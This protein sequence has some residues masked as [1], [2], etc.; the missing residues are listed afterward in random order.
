MEQRKLMLYNPMRLALFLLVC[1]LSLLG[2]HCNLFAG[3]EELASAH[4][5]QACGPTDGPS[6]R[7]LLTEEEIGCDGVDRV[8][9]WVPGSPA[10]VLIWSFEGFAP[11][12]PSTLVIDPEVHEEGTAFEGGWAQ[13]CD[14]S[15]TCVDVERGTVAFSA[16]PKGAPAGS[17]TASVE[18]AFEDGSTISERYLVHRCKPEEPVLCG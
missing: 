15:G 12:V 14:A 7:I 17:I 4:F 8:G 5:F 3:E 11:E 16:A 2:L 13:R 6:F 1:A 10:H 9:S 18:L